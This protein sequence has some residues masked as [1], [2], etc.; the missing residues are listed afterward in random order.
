M[1]LERQKVIYMRTGVRIAAILRDDGQGPYYF[2]FLEQPIPYI[3]CGVC[4][5][6][7]LITGRNAVQV[8]KMMYVHWKN[9][10]NGARSLPAHD[11]RGRITMDDG[12][13]ALKP[14]YD[15]MPGYTQPTKQRNVYVDVEAIVTCFPQLRQV[16]EWLNKETISVCCRCLGRIDGKRITCCSD[17]YIIHVDGLRIPG[18]NMVPIIQFTPNVT[19]EL[20]FQ[21][22]SLPR[23]ALRS[24]GPN[25][26]CDLAAQAWITSPKCNSSF[27]PWNVPVLLLVHM[28]Q[29]KTKC[30]FLDIEFSRSSL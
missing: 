13:Q 14:F 15:R 17:A 2:H 22:T 26:S 19:E 23:A 29:S 30:P 8:S 24:Q 21:S 4:L 5:R 20:I 1:E 7:E 3:I 18:S 16:F 25:S 12:R 11:L 27:S 10:M 6:I 28:R 9:H